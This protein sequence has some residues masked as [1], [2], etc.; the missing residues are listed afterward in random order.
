MTITP[1]TTT[2]DTYWKICSDT[3]TF[4]L[5]GKERELLGDCNFLTKEW[6]MQRLLDWK[7]MRGL[8]SIHTLLGNFDGKA[9]HK[10]SQIFVLP[11]GEDAIISKLANLS[12]LHGI[13]GLYSGTL[14]LAKVSC[15]E[16]LNIDA[17]VMDRLQKILRIA[18]K[19]EEQ[20]L[21]MEEQ[22]KIMRNSLYG[23]G[24]GGK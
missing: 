10:Q 7:P 3:Y 23:F 17:D 9:T 8:V 5:E 20:R 4:P 18:S 1:Q 24:G 14:W 15:A 6:I 21:W 2:I 12:D 13:V 16:D 19:E 22:K 11:Q